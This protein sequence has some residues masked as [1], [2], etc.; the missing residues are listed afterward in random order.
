MHDYTERIEELNGYAKEEGICYITGDSIKSFDKIKNNDTKLGQAGLILLDAGI[1]CATWHTKKGRLQ[2]ECYDENTYKSLFFYKNNIL[3]E[4]LQ[5]NLYGVQEY[6][7]QKFIMRTTFPIYNVPGA[8]DIFNT[9]ATLSIGKAGRTM[10]DPFMMGFKVH[11]PSIIMGGKID[12]AGYIMNAIREEGWNPI[13]TEHIL[14]DEAFI[15]ILHA[16]Y[17]PMMVYSKS[18]S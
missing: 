9:I 12:T 11:V 3:P 17:M 6:I 5:F 15:R 16:D 7:N 18:L 2:I 8:K 10:K 13:S 14:Y 4:I 1:L